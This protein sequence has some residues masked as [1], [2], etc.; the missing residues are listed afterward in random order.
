MPADLEKWKSKQIAAAVACGVNAL[1]AARAVNEFL[2]LLPAGADPDTY[3]VPARQL[4]QPLPSEV[5][6]VDV[7][8]AWYGEA[9]ARWARLL[10]ATGEE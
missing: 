4:E 8:A 3:I 7:R 2:T 1:D 5:V 10:D 6:L 9:D